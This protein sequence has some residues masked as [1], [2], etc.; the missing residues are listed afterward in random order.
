MFENRT[1]RL[2]GERPVPTLVFTTDVEDS[3]CE[4]PLF[5]LFPL[6]LYLSREE[7]GNEVKVTNLSS[8][9]SV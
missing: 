8:G 7:K 2:V 9:F 6:P 5:P 1:T 4:I 3:V